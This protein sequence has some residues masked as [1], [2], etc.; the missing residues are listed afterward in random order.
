MTS[1]QPLR[2]FVVDADVNV[3]AVVEAVELLATLGATLRSPTSGT[4]AGVTLRIGDGRPGSRACLTGPI[5]PLPGLPATVPVRAAGALLALSALAA[6]RAKRTAMVHP[7]DVVVT[8]LLPLVMAAA[9]DAPPPPRSEPVPWRDGWLAA[10]LGA[11]GDQEC[12]ERMVATLPGKASVWEL[13]QE[14][15]SWRLPVVPYRRWSQL[16]GRG[17]TRG[18]AFAV[19]TTGTW[20]QPRVSPS[21]LAGQAPLARVRVL[22]ATVMWA[23]PLATWL[24][25]GLGACVT[26]IEPTIRPDGARAPYGGGIYPH[27]VLV[28]G[29]G[30]RSGLFNALSRGKCRWDLDLR[31]PGAADALHSA[32][33]ET[34]LF[35]DNLSPRARSQLGLTATDLLRTNPH[36]LTVTVPAFGP[37]DPHREWVAYGSQVHAISGLAWNVPVP[38]PGATAYADALTGLIAA[39]VAVAALV[40]RDAGWH[41]SGDVEVPLASSVAG[42]AP[43]PDDPERLAADP[44]GLARSVLTEHP[45]RFVPLVVDG[46]PRAHPRYPTAVTQ[47]DGSP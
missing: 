11:P 28:P 29:D 25:Q 17:S 6:I 35:V 13:C 26:A 42:L 34:D 15:Q 31:L 27:G 47:K 46:E 4:G 23:G 21:V 5:E 37:A 1:P 43:H 7:A 2:G 38:Q 32:V 19:G 9:Y 18:P 10:E 33:A 3:P 41:P 12:F 36:L 24:L 44:A 40:G 20:G 16:T 45:D 39:V 30:S 8:L 22:D 14:A